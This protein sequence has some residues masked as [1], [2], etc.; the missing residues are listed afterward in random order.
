MGFIHFIY[1]FYLIIILKRPFPLNF[2]IS[3][4]LQRMKT[5]LRISRCLF[6]PGPR[7]PTMSSPSFMHIF[8][9]RE[10]IRKLLPFLQELKAPLP[11][12]F[13][14][15]V[16][17]IALSAEIVSTAF[18]LCSSVFPTPFHYFIIVV[19]KSQLIEFIVITGLEYYLFLPLPPLLLHP[20][21]KICFQLIHL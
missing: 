6:C 10:G 3:R 5:Y 14:N 11:H 19:F 21:L 2:N 7:S 4:I 18:R 1:S 17:S 16:M 8:L 12:P 20:S 9:F 15:L 13:V